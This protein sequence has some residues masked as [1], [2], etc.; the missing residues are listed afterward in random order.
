MRPRT[1]YE[2]R[3]A[4]LNATLSETIANKD[5]EW[6]K[7]VSKDWHFGNAHFCYFTITTNIQEFEVKRL[8]RGY[9]FTD[10][11]ASHFFFVEIIREFS[12]D[13]NKL[14]FAKKRQM[15]AYYDCF[16]YSSDI[17]LRTISENYAGYT[18]T[19][20]FNLSCASHP[21]S[22]GEIQPCSRF[23]PKELA[24]I[25]CNN[26]VAENLYKTGDG[27]FK[28]LI[29]RSHLKETCRAITL[30]KRHGFVFNDENAPLWFDMV[31]A[32]IKCKKDYHN[33]VFIAPADLRATHDRFV[34]MMIRKQQQEEII[35]KN[36]KAEKKVK[37]EFDYQKIYDKKRSRFFDMVLK[38]GSLSVTVLK[39]IDEFKQEAN[40][41]HN[42]V[43]SS[44]YWNMK[45]HPQSLILLACVA[46]NR[47]EL[48]EVNISTYEIVQSFGK[49]NQFTNYHKKIVSF[50]RKNMDTIKR[51][52]ENEIANLKIA[53]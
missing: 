4:Q 43:Y 5:I 17:E 10:K 40:Y 41:F 21:Q 23:E 28:Y 6:F 31:Y 37:R 30:A 26:P 51:Y 34:S 35:R 24:R 16:T 50:I 29:Y 18:L 39:N 53:V 44:E 48:I 45:S 33:P 2:K 36:R 8:Y 9:K 1:N 42:C 38:K 15:G 7:K 47:A 3:V 11:N 12:E 25:I 19:D 13:G 22:A 52:N 46:G 49:Y 14:Y 27:L 32:I 20:L